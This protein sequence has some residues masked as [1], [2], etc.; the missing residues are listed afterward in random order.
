MHWLLVLEYFG[1]NICH[2]SGVDKIIADTLSR[3]SS[4]FVDKYEPSTKK[5]Q[6]RVNEL[7][8]II[9]SENNKD[10]FPLNILNVQ[11]EKQKYLRKV[12][13]TLRKSILDRRSGYF[14]QALDN[15]KIICYSK[16]IK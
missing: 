11:G 7:F 16:K 4:I 15:I 8:P 10:C 2:I 14:K 13:S 3:L 1:P 5:A 12:H 6:C 9:R